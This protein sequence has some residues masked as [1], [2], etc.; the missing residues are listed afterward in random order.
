MRPGS[1]TKVPA[2]KRPKI[3]KPNRIKP[4]LSNLKRRLGAAKLRGSA[5][6]AVTA[7]VVVMLLG[8]YDY[9]SAY[10][11]VVW[12]NDHE[13]GVVRDAKDVEKFVAHLTDRCGTLYGMNMEPD[14]KIDLVKEFRPESKPSS[15]TVLA[16]IRQQMTFRTDAYMITV[17]GSPFVPVGSEEDLDM[18]IDSLKE[19]YSQS[20]NGVKVLDVFVVEEL[21]IEPCS[22][23]PDKIRSADQVV[24]L[25]VHDYT[26]PLQTAFLQDISGRGSL[27]SRQSYSYESSIPFAYIASEINIEDEKLIIDSTNVRVTTVEEATVTEAIPFEIE[28]VYDEELWVV[29]K[30][31]TTPGKDGEKEIVYHI[32]RENGV[33]LHRTKINETI[34]EEPVTQ[35]ESQGTAKVP[36]VGTGLFNWP[37]EGGGE[38]TPGR[39]FSSWHTG[40]DIHGTTGTNIL[41]AD[42]GVVWF[43][44]RGGS[45][46]NYLILYHGSFWT[47]YLHN[48]ENLVKEG[49]AV[50]QGDV[51]ATL[52]STG[53]SSGPHL[54]FEIRHDDGSGEWHAYYQHKPLD[55]L[56]FF[57]P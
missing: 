51:I 32:T 18:V 4:F 6:I 19:S 39:G 9:M 49:D 31:I 42:S 55:P 45:Q 22:V 20:G 37:V 52:G 26:P 53:R 48:Q 30:E 10:V 16:S 28:I 21:S 8:V 15:D 47:L 17:N 50:E 46:G 57:R 13:V 1:V 43:S 54:H 3:R 5:Y 14:A 29:Q 11:Y 34:L 24:S 44:G 27:E 2:G 41:A 36:S 23:E 56:K 25:L 40:I 33:E 35:V 38:V 7:I 12:L